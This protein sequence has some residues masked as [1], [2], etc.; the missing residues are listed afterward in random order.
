M[1]PTSEAAATEKEVDAIAGAA[2]GIAAAVTPSVPKEKP[3]TGKAQVAI[4]DYDPT[5]AR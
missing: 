1:E 3:P 4:A 5:K 2:S